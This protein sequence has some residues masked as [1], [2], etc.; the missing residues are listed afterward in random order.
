[1][2]K[3]AENYIILKPISERFNRIAEEMT[4]DDISWMIKDELRAQLNTIDFK[5]EIQDIVSEYI[6]NNKDKI[7]EMVE[8]SIQNKFK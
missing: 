6:E 7:S 1:M 2:P 3:Q 8:R 5:W 4:D